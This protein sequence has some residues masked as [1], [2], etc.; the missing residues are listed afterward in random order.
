MSATMLRPD[1]SALTLVLATPADPLTVLRICRAR[2]VEAQ[3]LATIEW[4][5]LRAAEI[6]QETSVVLAEVAKALKTHALSSPFARPSRARVNALVPALDD[7][8]S[9][10]WKDL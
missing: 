4:D 7:D 10:A 3:D 5:E 2:L 8:T 1:A 9:P 6:T